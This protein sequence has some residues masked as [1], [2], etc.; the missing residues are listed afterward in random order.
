LETQTWRDRWYWKWILREWTIHVWS[1]FLWLGIGFSGGFYDLCFKDGCLISWPDPIN[2]SGSSVPFFY[3]RPTWI[4]LKQQPVNLTLT[5]FVDCA[6]DDLKTI[7]HLLTSGVPTPFHPW[8]TWKLSR[9]F[10]GPLKN[11]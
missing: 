5:H 1:E 9:D 7:L 2:L 4:L 3:W 10:C 6:S 11:P 8:H